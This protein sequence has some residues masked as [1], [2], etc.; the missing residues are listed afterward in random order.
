MKSKAILAMFLLLCASVLIVFHPSTADFYEDFAGAQIDLTNWTIYDVGGLNGTQ[1]GGEF[2]VKGT[3]DPGETVPGTLGWNLYVLIY[4]KNYTGFVDFSVVNNITSWTGEMGVGIG[5]VH[6]TSVFADNLTSWVQRFLAPTIDAVGYLEAWLNGSVDRLTWDDQDVVAG[7]PQVQR[8][9]VHENRSA[10]FILNGATKGWWNITYPV[11]NPYILV[12]IHGGGATLEASFDD[13][14]LVDSPPQAALSVSDPNPNVDEFVLFDGSQSPYPFDLAG[15]LFDFGDGE[16]TGWISSST[17]YHSYSAEGSYDA[18]LKVRADNGKESDWASVTICVDCLLPT[19]AF[20]VDPTEVLTDVLVHFSANG[21]SDSDGQIV[22]YLFDF[23]DGTTSGWIMSSYVSHIYEDGGSFD[24]RVKAVDDDGHETGWSAPVRIE[25]QNR[26][27]LA[28][29]WVEDQMIVEGETIWFDALMSRDWDGIVVDYFYDFGDG[30]SSGWLS[31]PV[32]YHTYH[33]AGMYNA[34]LKVRDD[35]G[36]ESGQTFVPI[37][38]VEEE[39]DSGM[40][41]LLGVII[42]LESVILVVVGFL[43]IQQRK[44]IRETKEESGPDLVEDQG[45]E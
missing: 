7:L 11:F 8:M 9:I 28:V 23:G 39:A 34:S 33:E 26:A 38:V 19:V 43:A 10:E 1:V 35:E 16:S 42:L 37:S 22:G 24:A 12:G 27:P 40:L 3:Y 13:F 5:V 15:Y 44:A 31:T 14:T 18:R 30:T 6:N 32:I 4:N 36:E 25:V 21:S 45:S 29:L 17:A 2:I 41:Y 20:S